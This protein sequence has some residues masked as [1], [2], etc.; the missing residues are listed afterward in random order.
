MKKKLWIVLLFLPA[1]AFAQDF[2]PKTIAEIE[3]RPIKPFDGY[4]SF[5]RRERDQSMGSVD[6]YHLINITIAA[7]E[8]PKISAVMPDDSR[9]ATKKGFVEETIFWNIPK[10]KSDALWVKC[11]YSGTSIELLKKVPLNLNEC[12]AKNKNYIDAN[13]SEFVS[14]ECH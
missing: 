13:Y 5:S 9:Y 11:E 7:G 3:Q 12:V 10:E 1:V 6:Q 4:E 8:R 2:C 14:F